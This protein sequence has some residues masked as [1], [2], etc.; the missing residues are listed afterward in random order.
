MV[1]IIIF[2]SLVINAQQPTLSTQSYTLEHSVYDANFTEKVIAYFLNP[3]N[4]SSNILSNDIEKS[5]IW[6][7]K[8]LGFYRTELIFALKFCCEK[9]IDIDTVLIKINKN[10][11]SIFEIAKEYN[12]NVIENFNRSKE[13]KEKIEKELDNKDLIKVLIDK[14][15]K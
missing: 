13:I 14:Y 5:K 11:K 6:E 9:N 4:C 10:K 2:L 15:F 1:N 12:Y 7:F 8:R 3:D